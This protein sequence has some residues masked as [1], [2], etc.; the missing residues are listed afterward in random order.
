MTK[1]YKYLPLAGLIVIYLLL[2][3]KNPYSARTLI[4]NLEPYPDTLYYSNPAWNFV[5]N[6]GF[7]MQSFDYQNKII[8]PPLYSIYLIPFFALFQDVRSFYFANLLLI[9]GSLILFTHIGYKV[10]S[11]KLFDTLIVAFI[12]FLF[13]TNFYIYSLP[14]LLM[15]ENITLLLSMFALYLL[16][17]AT[18]AIRSVFAGILGVALIMIKFSNAPLMGSFYALYAGKVLMNK[19]NKKTRLML[20]LSLF[21]SLL[22]FVIYLLASQIFVGHKNLSS[23]NGFSSIYFFQNFWQYLKVLIGEQERFLWYNNRMVS[24]ILAVPTIIG[25]A[26]GLL[27]SRLRKITLQMLIYG[28]SVIVFMSFFYTRDVRYILVVYPIMLLFVGFAFLFIKERFDKVS[29]IVLMVCVALGYLLIP[30]V[31]QIPKERGIITFK[32][33]IGLNFRHKEEPWNYKAVLEF[34]AYFTQQKDKKPYLGTFLP[35]YFVSFYSNGNYNYLP[36]SM[37]QEFYGDKQNAPKIFPISLTEY[38]M[39]LLKAN[40]DIYISPAYQSNFVSWK[41][42]Y[43]FLTRHFNLKLVKSGCYNTCN[44]YRVTLPDAPQNSVQ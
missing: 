44:I 16:L 29:A 36:I 20:G 7:V 35:P 40:N 27:T 41:Q 33:Q 42:D 24:P 28:L 26:G 30:Q 21:A 10:F 3:F 9:V 14:P 22:L 8:T 37:G 1:Y 31:G 38:Y 18:S 4:P 6:R 5:H 23:G 11:N 2:A 43:D 12:G 25:I 19:S 13:V 15:A 17:S 39:S 32:K 34:N